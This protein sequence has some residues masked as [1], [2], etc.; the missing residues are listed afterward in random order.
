[1]DIAPFTSESQTSTPCSRLKAAEDLVSAC[2]SV[3]FV[4]IQNHGVPQSELD[5]AF[6]LSQQ[7]Y[8]LPTEDK[9]K[10]PHPPGWAVHRGYSWP[11]LEK[12]SGAMSKEDDEEFVKRLREVQDYKV[13][14]V[15]LP[16]S[17]VRV[18]RPLGAWAKKKVTGNKAP[19]PLPPNLCMES[20]HVIDVVCFFNNGRTC[21]HRKATKSAPSP[22]P[23]NPTSG[24]PT[25]SSRPG[26]PS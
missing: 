15:V 2:R 25:R 14:H 23:T 18:R 19:F 7:F 26:A 13:R 24:R 6:A 5:R 21:V 22:T 11:G 12:V 16:S 9:M 17:R 8:A 10:A 4:Y 20:Q 1:M 3:G